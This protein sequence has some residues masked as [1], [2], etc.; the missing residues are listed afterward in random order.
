[1]A[2]RRMR[3]R[4]TNIE[5]A[6]RIYYQYPELSSKEIKELF[7]KNLSSS[8]LSKYKNMAKVIQAKR[9]IYTVGMSTVNTESAY[10]AWGLD[11]TNLENRL[12]KLR[13]LHYD[14]QR[15]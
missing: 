13:E 2:Q 4:V 10:E 8:T 7:G 1:M 5:T 3:C 11:I 9:N 14:M 6:V 12:K 15:A